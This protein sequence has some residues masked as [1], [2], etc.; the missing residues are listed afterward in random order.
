MEKLESSNVVHWVLPWPTFYETLRTRFVRNRL[1]VGQFES[2]L[3]RPAVAKLDDRCYRDTA[4]NKA[5][6]CARRGQP[7]SMVDCLLLLIID[8]RQ[9]R[10]DYLATFNLRDF[11]SPCS[12]R[13][14]S[15]F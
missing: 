8:D 14:I 10:I 1:A 3:R 6:D 9:V 4:M 2:F 12:K 15:L 5:F 13:G 7:I 11:Q